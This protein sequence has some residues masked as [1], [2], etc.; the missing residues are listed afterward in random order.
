MPLVALQLISKPP[1]MVEICRTLVA[2][3][4]QPSEVTSLINPKTARICL[5]SGDNRMP[6]PR[7][8]A[9]CSPVAQLEPGKLDFFPVHLFPSIQY[10]ILSSISFRPPIVLVPLVRVFV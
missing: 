8:G 9:T 5:P 6:R 7:R 4:G 2:E 3:T 10:Q 1:E